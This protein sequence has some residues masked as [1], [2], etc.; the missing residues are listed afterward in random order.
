MSTAGVVN[1]EGSRIIFT[2]PHLSPLKDNSWIHWISEY[3]NTAV[4]LVNDADAVAIGAASLGYLKGYKTVGIMPVGTG[5]GFTVWRNGRRWSPFFSY[6][7]M[8]CISIPM[9]TYDQL[10]SAVSFAK[11]HP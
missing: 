7:L 10:A 3:L 8:G 11:R 6:T 9:G 4:I 2:A 1:Y 5:L